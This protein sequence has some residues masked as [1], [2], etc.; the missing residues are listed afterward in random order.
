MKLP[1]IAVVLG[2]LFGI[3]ATIF[4][5]PETPQGAAL[6]IIISTILV[7]VAVLAVN[8]LTQRKSEGATPPAAHD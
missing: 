2:L 3:A 5:A 8:K 1:L 4:I 6:L 7:T